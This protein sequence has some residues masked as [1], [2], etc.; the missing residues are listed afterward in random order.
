MKAAFSLL[1]MGLSLSYGWAADFIFPEF[2]RQFIKTIVAYRTKYQA[3]DND[4]KKTAL[5][6]ARGEDFK[7]LPGRPDQVKDWIGIIRDYGT[8]GNGRAYVTIDLNADVAVGTWSGDFSD[9]NDK[10]LIAQ[11]SKI[12]TALADMKP[13]NLV[14]FSGRLLRARNTTEEDRMVAPVWL[15]RFTSIDKLADRVTPIK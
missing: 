10:T 6:T 1:F 12:Y 9:A 4:L 13:G 2:E 7:K 3:A 8:T 11:N 14:R 15:F 5:V